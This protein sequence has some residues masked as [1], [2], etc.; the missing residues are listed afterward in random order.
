[1]A[2]K[3]QEHAKSKDWIEDVKLKSRGQ[4]QLAER[5]AE[6]ESGA[7]VGQYL[8]S[9]PYKCVHA[10]GPEPKTVI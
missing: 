3:S 4:R 6:S 9:G 10:S 1:M 7:K 8:N 2:A 5:M